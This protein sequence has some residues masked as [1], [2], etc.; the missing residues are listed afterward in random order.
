MRLFQT[1]TLEECCN[2]YDVAWTAKCAFYK[3]YKSSGPLRPLG[4][5]MREHRP[6]TLEACS[7][8]Y[9]DAWTANCIF[10][11]RYKSPGPL[12]VKYKN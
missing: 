4:R 11:T 3:T 12:Q 1:L 6:F 10:F 9:D 2:D 5:K 8:D 7:K